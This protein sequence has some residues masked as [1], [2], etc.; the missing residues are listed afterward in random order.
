MENISELRNAYYKKHPCGHYFDESTLKFFGERLSDMRL[1]KNTSRITDAHG[2]IH[3][4]YT[5]SR[6]QRKY[7]GGPRRTYA[8]FDTTTLEDVFPGKDGC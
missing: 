2:K 1:L 8:Y 3:E 7:P 4:C 6:L 5:I